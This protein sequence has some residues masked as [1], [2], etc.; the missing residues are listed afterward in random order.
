MSSDISVG[1]NKRKKKNSVESFQ[2]QPGDQMI[3][4]D[5]SVLPYSVEYILFTLF[6]IY[7]A[8]ETTTWNM[9][10]FFLLA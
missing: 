9:N 5:D 6:D 1:K 10:V 8:T 4:V 7:I 2:Y 3:S